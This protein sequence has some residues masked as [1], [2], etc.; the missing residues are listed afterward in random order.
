MTLRKRDDTGIFMRKYNIALC[1]ELAW[2]RI[3]SYVIHELK[4]QLKELLT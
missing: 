4:L 1:G 2:N 3:W